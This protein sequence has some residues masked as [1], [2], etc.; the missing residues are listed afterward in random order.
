MKQECNRCHVVKSVE[1]FNWRWKSLGIRQR[2]CRTCQNE[3]KANWYE[4]NKETH[5][6]NTYEKRVARMEDGREYVRQYLE[7]HPCVDCGETDPVILEFDHVRGDKKNTVMILVR[8]GYSLSA[9]QTEIAKCEVRCVK[10]HRKRTYK[11]SWRG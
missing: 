2:T 6:A 5:K 1:E 7:T 3:Q 8:G 9:I 11:G 10:C 4:R